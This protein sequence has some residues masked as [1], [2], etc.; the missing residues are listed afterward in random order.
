MRYLIEAARSKKLDR[1]IVGYAVAGWAVVQAASIATSAYLWPQWVLQL[2][3]S[4]ALI[5]LPIVLI[6]AWTIGVRAETGGTLT[7]S[8]ADIQVLAVLTGFLLVAEPL[9]IWAFW[10]RTTAPQ[11]AQAALHIALPNSVAVLP[12]ANASGDPGQRYFS[13]GIA[14]ELIGLLARNSALRVAA[15]T[16]SFY[17]EGKNEDIR[18]IAQ[19]LNVRAVLEGSVREEGQHVRIDADLIDASNGYQLWSDSYDREL[20]DILALQSEI[21]S[22]IA[23]ALA[24]RILSGGAP[25]APH[26]I[27]AS[28]YRQYL[29]GQYLLA[30]R[31]D[32]TVPKALE[33]FR[34]VAARAPDFADGRAGLAYA[35]LLQKARHP[36]Q[37]E[38]E[39]QLQQALTSALALDPTNPQTLTVAIE[40]A[41]NRWDWDAVIQYASI[42]KHT[43]AHTA[44]GAHGMYF[45]TG[46]FN[47]ADAALRWEEEFLRLDPLSVTAISSV[48]SAQFESGRF[49]DAIASADRRLA[50]HPD[51]FDL[52]D[53]KCVSL[54]FLKRFSEA[55]AVLAGLGKAGQAAAGARFDCE[56]FIA[57][58]SGDIARARAM[59]DAEAKARK[60]E[61]DLD[62]IGFL[63][64]QVGEYAEA[65]K[66]FAKAFDNRSFDFTFILGAPT[67]PA[68]FARRD[69]RAFTTRP[70]YVAWAEA[71][72]RAKT[73][74]LD[75]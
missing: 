41:G 33:I 38:L 3:I 61:H 21:A 4:A 53:F 73:A 50:S 45:G 18:T 40:D 7:P 65:T 62:S 16:S 49:A 31:T 70:D 44:I 26:S 1:I 48:V 57:A 59:L 63:Y 47:F 19:K 37:K 5:G 51:D 13:E 36:E 29:Q 46:M 27:D 71:R 2:I 72:E 17:F 39:P 20:R 10:P 64:A 55:R 58:K 66:W 28:V 32:E 23:R 8:R 22:A 43:G 24:P 42:L 56:F 75:K 54:T 11:I 52:S 74:L 15:R 12:F 25:R 68:F 60:A 9:S 34:R 6:G 30:Q 14:E 67:P 35:L 69:W